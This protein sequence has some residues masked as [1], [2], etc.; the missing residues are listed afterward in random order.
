MGG[1][2]SNILPDA[3][4][5]SLLERVASD[6]TLRG[7]MA[8]LA[9]RGVK[10]DYAQVWRSAHAEGLS[11]KKSVLP[12][13]QLR[14]IIARRRAQWKKYQGRLDPIRLVFIDETWVKTNM[15]PLRGWAPIGRRLHANVPY[16]HWRACQ[17]FCAGGHRMEWKGPSIWQSTRTCWISFSLV[18]T[19]KSCSPRTVCSTS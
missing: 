18:V 11:F 9:G 1:R 10:F 2:R 16:G 3:T 19:R 13:E 8:E 14:P 17:E 12:A 4:R 6:F 7:L 15:A 5:E